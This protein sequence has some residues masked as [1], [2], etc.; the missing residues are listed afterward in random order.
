M[1]R[2]SNKYPEINPQDLYTHIP[3]PKKKLNQVMKKHN[4]RFADRESCGMA[5]GRYMWLLFPDTKAIR[6]FLVDFDRMKRAYIEHDPNA[7]Q[8]IADDLSNLRRNL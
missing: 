5:C 1:I 7:I 4:L 6:E 8:S 3:L 2:F